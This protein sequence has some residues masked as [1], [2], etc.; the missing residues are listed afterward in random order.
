MRRTLLIP[1]LLTAS[2]AAAAPAM[3]AGSAVN[4]VRSHQ[5]TSGGIA[6]TGGIAG[7]HAHRVVG[8]GAARRRR[9]AAP[10]SAGRAARRL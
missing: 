1:A 6:E 2:L 7:R 5:T 3:A 8:D 4:Y 9:H 10:P